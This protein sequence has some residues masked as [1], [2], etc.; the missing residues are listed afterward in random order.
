[1][2]LSEEESELRALI[3]D[4]LVIETKVEVY[5]VE[6]NAATPSAV[7]VFFVGQKSYPPQSMGDIVVFL[8]KGNSKLKEIPRQLA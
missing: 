3:R 2:F 4:N 6:K 8:S 1:M 7:T 5:F